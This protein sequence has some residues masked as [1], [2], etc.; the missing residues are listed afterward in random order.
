VGCGGHQ[1]APQPTTTIKITAVSAARAAT[2]LNSDQFIVE[3]GEKSLR[4]SSP[5]GVNFTVRFYGTR[6]AANAAYARVGTRFG[7]RFATAVV[8]FAGNPPP[9]R[10]APPRVLKDIDLATIRHCVLRRSIVTTDG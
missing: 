7:A 5:Q 4:G 6:R 3:P 2:C 1:S 10:G 8:N 9:H